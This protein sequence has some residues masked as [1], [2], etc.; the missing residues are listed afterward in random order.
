[1]KTKVLVI[2][3]VHGRDFWQEPC[4]KWDGQIIFLGDYHDP[5]PWQVSTKESLANLKNLVDFYN[6]NKDRCIFLLGNH[7]CS[8]IGSMITCRYDVQYTKEVTELLRQL[9]I[10]LV[11]IQNNIIFSHAG[12]TQDWL[13][14]NNIDINDLLQF[15]WDDNR[16][17]QV[18]FYR[19]G[20]DTYSSPIWCDVREFDT[21]EKP[22]DYYQI[23]GHTQ[24]ELEPI[25]TKEFACLDVRKGFIVNTDNNTIELCS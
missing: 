12:I 19:G 20:F 10:K 15:H 1:M 14:Y 8:Y 6:S 13:Q 16:L 5:Y 18:S 4:T 7:E 17:N 25:I 11:H 22:K 2:P 23:F 21:C 9:P 3:D 24:L